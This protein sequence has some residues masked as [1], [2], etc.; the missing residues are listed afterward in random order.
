MTMKKIS[1]LFALS[2][3]ILA[4]CTEI[5]LDTSTDRSG[6]GSLS[7]NIPSLAPWLE[8]YVIE[9]QSRAFLFA[10]SADISLWDD[11][12]IMFG[13]V[14]VSLSGDATQ[15]PDSMGSTNLNDVPAGYFTLQV[16]I[17]N[18]AQSAEPILQGI[19]N[20][21]S[22]T[23]NN[24]T[25]VTVTVFPTAPTVLDYQ[26]AGQVDPSTQ[27][28][29]LELQGETWYY[30]DTGLSESLIYDIS[31]DTAG[32]D[33]RL[34]LFDEDG[35]F[36]HQNLAHGETLTLDSQQDYYLGLAGIAQ[37]TSTL[38]ITPKVDG[39]VYKSGH[40]TN[41][42]VV[43]GDEPKDVYFVFTN[44]RNYQT[45]GLPTV[46]ALSNQGPMSS[47][48][49]NYNPVN[50]TDLSVDPSE[51]VL[52]GREDITQWNADPPPLLQEQT[53][54]S[55]RALNYQEPLLLTVGTDTF[56]YIQDA[57]DSSDTVPTTLR[58]QALNVPTSFGNKSLFLWVADDSW[59]T[60]GT[61]ANLVNQSMVNNLIDAFLTAGTDNDIYDW[62]TAIYG[63]EWSSSGFSELIA[64]TDEIHIVL[65]DINDDNS[66]T[67]GTVGYFWSK[68]NFR[69]AT[70]SGSNE[71]ILFALDSVLV[72]TPEGPTWEPS[73][74]WF[75]ECISTL[76]H[77]FQHMINFYQRVVERNQ[78]DPVWINEMLSMMT[79][80]LLADKLANSGPRGVDGTDYTAGAS[81]NLLGRLPVF[82]Y[83][84]DDPLSLWPDPTSA[85]GTDHARAYAK[86]YA[87]GAY[88][89]RTYGG[90][91]FAK[92]FYES[93]H[94]SY[95]STFRAIQNTIYVLTG[96]DIEADELMENWGAAVLLSDL[97]EPQE[98]YTYNHGGAYQQ[99]I[100][101]SWLQ[102]RRG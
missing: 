86:S 62:V 36:L 10:T 21:L 81:G 41:L 11:D 34:F 91:A 31:L 83:F 68:D 47:R 67:G 25:D 65:F 30:L 9:N 102:P 76:A 90:A 26:S 56:N 18:S 100:R 24:T 63:E 77:E 44:I 45:N 28:A 85:T 5:Q 1:T 35:L 50:K 74:Y 27:E 72:A 54:P 2:A 33:Q 58:G 94:P 73:D 7:I 98:F 17:Y 70:V 32:A 14:N 52:R 23:N 95:N 87:F 61:K 38:S 53:G 60:G 46:Q 92:E 19:Y 55:S 88:L 101:W 37:G 79:E 51:L 80:D 40:D 69:A 78:S 93:R 71:K 82:N 64:P 59:E 39:Y 13:P 42:R 49:L 12:E 43:V 15:D 4:S 22:I 20:N 8:P 57:S 48:A 6:N 75:Q 96:E 97:E 84:N 99:R 29:I 3:L 66:T 16:D 89:S